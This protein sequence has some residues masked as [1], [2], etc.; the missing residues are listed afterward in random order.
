[1][2]LRLGTSA[3]RTLALRWDLAS[4]AIAQPSKPSGWLA[5]WDVS[6]SHNG[7]GP[8]HLGAHLALRLD[9]AGSAMTQ[10]SKPS[11][12]LAGWDVSASHNGAGPGNLSAKA[13]GAEVGLSQLGHG[14]AQQ[15]FWMA[16]LGAQRQGI[17]RRPGVCQRHF[18]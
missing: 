7:A 9:L 11:G 10:P 12:W 8:G 18:A 6:A 14:P 1:M 16:G 4:S 13:P 5:G 2:A 17:W 15:A 3:P